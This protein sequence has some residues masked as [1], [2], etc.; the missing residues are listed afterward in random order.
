MRIYLYGAV[1]IAAGAIVLLVGCAATPAAV[2]T[3]APTASSTPKAV[4]T[5]ILTR[6]ALADLVVST[7]GIGDLKMG[8]PV[9]QDAADLALISYNPTAC[10]SADLGVNAGD[11]NAGAWTA[12]YPAAQNA[13]GPDAPFTVITDQPTQTGPVGLIAVWSPGIHTDK[14]I[15]I[16]DSLDKLKAAY[17]TFSEV[18]AGAVSDVYVVRG[19]K[20]V[21]LF[22][23]AKDLAGEPGYWAANELGTVLWIT[24]QKPGVPVNAVAG[25]DGGPSPCP[26]GA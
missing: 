9:P 20:G 25:S 23:V 24:V 26:T 19:S 3:H 6:P 18:V 10:V 22:E 1:A 4:P 15:G 13:Y 8:F 5:P 16:G 21:I 2:S 14:G 17:P 7:E 12:N 11:P